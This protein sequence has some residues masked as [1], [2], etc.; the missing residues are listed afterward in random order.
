MCSKD[1]P[2][3]SFSILVFPFWRLKTVIFH[4]ILVFQ[5]NHLGV[6]TET[7]K[8]NLLTVGDFLPKKGIS[9]D[10]NFTRTQRLHHFTWYLYV[11]DL[12]F[13]QFLKRSQWHLVFLTI[14]SPS[15]S[16]SNIKTII[17]NPLAW[18]NFFAQ[19]KYSVVLYSFII[20]YWS[21]LGNNKVNKNTLKTAKSIQIPKENTSVL[22]FFAHLTR[23]GSFCIKH[24]YFSH[25]KTQNPN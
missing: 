22:K 11:S 4:F 15:Y 10:V 7:K 2:S 17:Q 23:C 19:N 24:N 8:D 5:V 13:T 12:L 18:I 1:A 25:F 16:S 21:E 3:N 20:S 9:D 14:I 6:G